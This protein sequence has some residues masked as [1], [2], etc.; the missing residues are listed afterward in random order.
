MQSKQE[1]FNNL[2]IAMNMLHNFQ[3]Y[4]DFYE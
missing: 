1:N 3:Y 2:L 4:Y